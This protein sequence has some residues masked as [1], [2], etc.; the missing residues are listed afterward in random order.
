MV[1]ALFSSDL[2]HAG[3]GAAVGQVLFERHC[4]GPW[5]GVSTGI[6]S[7]LPT[8]GTRPHQT[9]AP[10]L[11][12][13]VGPL[14]PEH[15]SRIGDAAA[16]AVQHGGDVIPFELGPRLSQRSAGARWTCLTIQRRVEE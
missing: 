10:H 6:H 16:L 4:I 2:I 13:K 14:N 8:S 9:E 11:A 1:H 15:P 7:P 5:R 3:P 12:V